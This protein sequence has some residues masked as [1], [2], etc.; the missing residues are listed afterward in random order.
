MYCRIM[1]KRP[2][3]AGFSSLEYALLVLALVVG[4]VAAQTYLTRAISFKWRDASDAFG[5]G[6]QYQVNGIY[7]VDGKNPTL[8]T[9][10][11]Y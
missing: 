2:D 11:E 3:R 9:R 7:Q 5:S 1:P 10:V 4:L 6:R 8:V